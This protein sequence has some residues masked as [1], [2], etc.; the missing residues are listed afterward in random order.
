MK[1]VILY[2]SIPVL[3][4]ITLFTCANQKTET[5]KKAEVNPLEEGAIA[6]TLSPV[7]QVNISKP[8]SA[9]GLVATKNE[10]RLS[11]KIG[12]VIRKIYVEEGQ[13]VQKG[14]V[15][16]SLDLTEIDAQVNQAKS[17]VEKWKRDL[18]RVQRLYKDSAATLETLQ[19][20][21]TA[22]DVALEN[23]SVA[24]FNR[25]YA[26]IRASSSGKVLKK[27]LNEGELAGPGT[28]VFFLNSAGQDEWLIKLAVADIDWVRTKPGDKAN[29]SL[30]VFPGEILKGVVSQIGEGADPFTGLYP[31]EVSLSGNGKRLASGLFASVDI[32]PAKPLSLS[33]IPIEALVEGNGNKAYVF[34]LDADQKHIKK[35]LVNVTFIDGG[36]AFVNKGLEGVEKVITSG[37]GFLTDSSVVTVSTIQ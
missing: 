12:G 19:N 21:Q 25:E 27:F 8:V 31:I 10:S 37:S 4:A 1:K 7:Q 13:S 36:S 22:Y 6:V 14:Q 5:E 30:D 17:N 20:I 16:A 32:I 24:E 26:T 33:Q 34:V 3:I 2:S 18:E 15:L 11:F 35:I 29:V 9:S 28:P 23:K